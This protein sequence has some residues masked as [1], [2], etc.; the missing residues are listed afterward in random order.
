MSL[1]ETQ[2]YVPFNS[3]R[4][5]KYMAKEKEKQDALNAKLAAD[6]ALERELGIRSGPRYADT[7]PGAAEMNT[8]ST[9]PAIAERERQTEVNVKPKHNHSCGTKSDGSPLCGLSQCW[10]KA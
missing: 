6:E 8:R 7:I 9:F 3:P 4:A 10:M 1:H 2:T 5:L